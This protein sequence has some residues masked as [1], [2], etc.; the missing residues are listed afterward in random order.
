M[1]AMIKKTTDDQHF[2]KSAMGALSTI[3]F[4]FFAVMHV[5]LSKIQYDIGVMQTFNK[6]ITLSL[7]PGID[8]SKP[9][10]PR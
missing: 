9:L 1:N 2:R 3:M 7:F 10:A 8:V 4:L 6:A 5:S